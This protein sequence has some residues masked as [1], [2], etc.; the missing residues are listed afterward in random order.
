M[1][2]RYAIL[3]LVACGRPPPVAPPS[4]EELLDDENRI[5]IAGILLPRMP[6]DVAP[7]DPELEE[8]WERASR[9]LSM[10]T[11][12]PPAGDSVELET[13]AD[14]ELSEWITR[15]G[16]AIGDAQRALERARTGPSP[17]HSV[18]ASAILGLAYSRFALD[19]RGIPA[20]E[21][22]ADDPDRAIAFREALRSAARPLWQRALDAFGS[23][24]S[25]AGEQPAHSLDHWREFCD[26]EIR[27]AGAMLPDAGDE[28]NER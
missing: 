24:S 18:V 2:V 28:N 12:R 16:Q 19:L 6:V 15:R 7:T 5:A 1:S 26:G 8:G 14:E 17:E 20:P 3:L 9:A 23:C 21:L 4:Y 13:W 10:P 25:V 27:S 11:P 22:F